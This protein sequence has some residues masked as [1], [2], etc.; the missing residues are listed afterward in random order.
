MTTGSLFAITTCNVYVFR[1][2]L[3]RFLHQI[4]VLFKVAGVLIYSYAIR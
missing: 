3:S 2:I 1:R 4:H